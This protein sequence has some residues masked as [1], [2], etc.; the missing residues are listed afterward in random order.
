[1]SVKLLTC[2]EVKRLQSEEFASDVPELR[3]QCNIALTTQYRKL[4]SSNT[5]PV[6]ALAMT[7]VGAIAMTPITVS[8]I[9]KNKWYYHVD[10]I[11]QVCDELRTN[12]FHVDISSNGQI[13]SIYAKS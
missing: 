12:G 6:G 9:D 3:R 4:S 10:A 2:E 13:L 11:M 1:M 7:P 8:L 5:S